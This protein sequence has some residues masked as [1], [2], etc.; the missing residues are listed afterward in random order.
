MNI[1]YP[2]RKGDLVQPQSGYH[3]RGRTATGIVLRIINTTSD[4]KPHKMYEVY[5]GPNRI[6]QQEPGWK[7]ERIT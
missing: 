3:G 4:D 5:W 2:I 1:S 7:I 6:P